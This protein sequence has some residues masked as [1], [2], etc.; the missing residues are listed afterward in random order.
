MPRTL[1]D[2]TE[3]ERKACVGM[4]C[5][6]GEN[7]LIIRL[8]NYNKVCLTSP[9]LVMPIFEESTK[10]TPIYELPRAWMPDGKPV[11]QCQ[12]NQHR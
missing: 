4:W 3:E 10:I 11:E 6:V 9:D 8:V 2:M 1:A 5:K 12:A 7:W